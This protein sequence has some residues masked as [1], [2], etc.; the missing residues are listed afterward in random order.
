MDCTLQGL[1]LYLVLWG[2][3]SISGGTYRLSL[4]SNL[5]PHVN[6]EVLTAPSLKMT[7]F[8]NVA[9]CSLVEV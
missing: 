3:T 2:I 5:N 8:W 4:Q 6:F 9:L 7:V 1:W